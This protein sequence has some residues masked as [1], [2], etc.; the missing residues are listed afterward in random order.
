M[1]QKCNYHEQ[2]GFAVT[3]FFYLYWPYVMPPPPPNKD[4][5]ILYLW[6]FLLVFVKD[7]SA[8]LLHMKLEELNTDHRRL[9]KK[10]GRILIVCVTFI[11]PFVADIELT[12]AYALRVNLY[13]S[14]CSK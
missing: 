13:S 10:G 12:L 5:Q 8:H 1:C 6:I 14:L 4:H 2:Q 3:Q 11:Q 7:V 9:C